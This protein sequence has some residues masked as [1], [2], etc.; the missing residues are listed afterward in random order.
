MYPRLSAIDHG[1]RG[2]KGNLSV[3]I[4][5]HTFLERYI[6]V[7]SE[8]EC[9]PL[10]KRARSPFWGQKGPK[11]GLI[12]LFSY[13]PYKSVTNQVRNMKFCNFVSFSLLLHIE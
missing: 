13:F 9:L 5:T 6:S 3:D 2:E 7:L 4:L 1:P 12:W 10:K 8:S 11:K